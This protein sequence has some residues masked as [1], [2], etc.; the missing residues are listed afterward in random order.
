MSRVQLKLARPPAPK[1]RIPYSRLRRAVE[2]FRNG[3]GPRE[4]KKTNS[5]NWLAAVDRLGD[6]WVYSESLRVSRKEA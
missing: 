1:P 5:R 2:L 3:Y 6:K 4:Q